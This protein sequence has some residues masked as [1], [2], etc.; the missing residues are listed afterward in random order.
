MDPDYAGE[1]PWLEAKEASLVAGELDVAE[2]A[3][4]EAMLFADMARILSGIHG[5]SE[6]TPRS[7]TCAG[8]CSESPKYTA[9]LQCSENQRETSHCN[10]LVSRKPHDYSVYIASHK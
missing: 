6:V 7:E 5:A 9:L 10:S 4:G 2:S 8:K 1:Q 3:I